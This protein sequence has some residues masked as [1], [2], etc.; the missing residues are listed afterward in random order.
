MCHTQIFV[1]SNKVSFSFIVRNRFM[2]LISVCVCLQ[3]TSGV[4]FSLIRG[5]Y[6]VELAEWQGG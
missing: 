4:F 5:S 1:E 6:L 2:V 3:L